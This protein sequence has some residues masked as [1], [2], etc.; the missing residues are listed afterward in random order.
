MDRIS[1]DQRSRN[2]ALVGGKNTLPEMTVRRALFAQGFR[3]RLHRKDLPGRPD[4][5]L[6]R[7]RVAVFVHGCFWHGHSCPR[8]RRPSSNADF[9]QAKIEGNIARD[10]QAV[11][12]IE[13]AGWTTRTLWQCRLEDDIAE[14][15]DLLQRREFDRAAGSIVSTR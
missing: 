1:P 11:A 6:P 15:V 8:G 10:R 12:D 7:F 4:I 3:Y 2:M 13:A 5:V 9:W 14:L